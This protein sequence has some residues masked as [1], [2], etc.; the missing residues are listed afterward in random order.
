M[1]RLD[2]VEATSRIRQF[3]INTPVIS[4]SSNMATED[5]LRYL[6]SGMN[7]VLP[8]P[9]NRDSV[10]RRALASTTCLSSAAGLL[11]S[12]L[13]MGARGGWVLGR[14]PRARHSC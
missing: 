14:G 5:M 9:F 2:G 7:D 6:S 1:P 8:K 11:T 12:G 3:D 10:K 13:G 4:M